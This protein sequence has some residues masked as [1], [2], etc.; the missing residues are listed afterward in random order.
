MS[1]ENILQ[2]LDSFILIHGDGHAFA[3]G[4]PV[5]FDDDRRTVFENIELR[6]V[7]IVKCAV[8]GGGDVVTFHELF[9]E[10]LR[11]LDLRRRLI[12]SERLDARVLEIVDDTFD[13]WDFRADEHPIVSV[14]L[15]EIDESGM[16][17][18]TQPRGVNTVAFHTRI[19]WRHGHF[20]NAFAA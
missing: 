16:I 7:E 1:H 17:G 20:V 5:R 9:G 18:G 6:I 13:Q 4:Q 3:C 12:R 8:C 15:H 14:V 19:T 2:C 11:S 10:I